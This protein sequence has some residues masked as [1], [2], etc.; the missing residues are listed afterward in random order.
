MH[1]QDE[2]GR[3]IVRTIPNGMGDLR[4]YADGNVWGTDDDG[5]N[6]IS[7]GQ[8]G[9]RSDVDLRADAAQAFEAMLRDERFVQTPMPA[10]VPAFRATPGYEHVNKAA[11]ALSALAAD[12][13]QG[14]T[15]LTSYPSELPSLDELAAA[16]QAIET[17][18]TFTH[19]QLTAFGRI[20]GDA[21]M[22]YFVDG[23]GACASI[24]LT[25]AP[26]GG[27]SQERR[28]DRRRR[29]RRIAR[30]PRHRP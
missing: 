9:G 10:N 22:G 8:V 12:V 26:S 27:T 14:F 3:E 5:R 15:R 6:V 21:S 4:V 7:L 25:A 11:D 18:R 1:E 16:V 19:D 23:N 29:A 13:E 2:S 17:S 24:A 28:R 20:V 30:D